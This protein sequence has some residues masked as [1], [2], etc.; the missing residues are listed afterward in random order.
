[1]VVKVTG[2]G[3]DEKLQHYYIVNPSNVVFNEGLVERSGTLKDGNG[4]P[5]PINEKK[6]FIHLEGKPLIVEESIKELLELFDV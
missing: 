5:I 1:M 4:Q 3:T 2:K 6:S